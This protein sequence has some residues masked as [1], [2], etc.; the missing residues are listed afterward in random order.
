MR[1]VPEFFRI[2]DQASIPMQAATTLPQEYIDEKG[3]PVSARS[4]AIP[5][6]AK[7]YPSW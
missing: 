3:N 7:P 4:G 2:R 6:A 5:K 1:Y